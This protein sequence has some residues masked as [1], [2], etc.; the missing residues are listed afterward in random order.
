MDQVQ[1]KNNILIVDDTPENLTVLLQM[2]TEQGYRVRPALSGEIALNAVQADPPDLILLDILMPEMDGYEVCSVLKADRQTEQIPIIFISALSEV[3]DI[4]KAFQS[5]GVDYVTKPFQMDEVL[6]RVRTHLG[7]Q[8]AVREKEE[9]QLLLQTILD[10]IENVIVTVDAQMRIINANRPLDAIC[11]GMPGAEGSFQKSLESGNCPCAEALRQTLESNGPVKEYRVKCSCEGMDRTLVLNTV[12]LIKRQDEVGGAVLVIKDIT[13][14]AAL[15][16]SLL[17]QHS[18]H[19]IIG[20]SEE[21]QK[22][23]TLLERTSELDVNM[24]ICGESGTG[25]ELIAEAIH[26]ASRR[27]AGPLV[28]VNCAALTESLLESELFGHVRGSFTGAV[29]DRV[30]RCQAAE[31]G[32]LFLDEIGDISPQFQAKLL[33]FLEQKEFE[34]IG[35]SKS[36]KAD[37]RVVAATNRDLS[38]KVKVR[39][40]REDLFFRL[41]GVLVQLPSLGE[42]VDDIPL[43]ASHFVHV[44]RKSLNKNIESISE[45]VTKLFLEYPW[46]GNVRELKSAI[47]YACALCP[48]EVI[49]K[50]HLPP[51]LF[52]E[53]AL[54]KLSRR[55]MDASNAEQLSQGSDKE[56]ILAMLE[57][58]DWNKAKAA[59]RL[60]VSRATLYAKLSK[61]GIEAPPEKS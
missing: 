47:H 34:R 49:Q 10:S 57:N 3:E 18:Y 15:E 25:K 46:P 36:R 11:A 27:A 23:F 4:V 26:Y 29:K 50:E 16:K 22:V 61:Y 42:R 55:K 52:A 54:E 9:A 51:E 14:L 56:S 59:R 24:L 48:E 6:A 17:E 44:F 40:F 7:L 60:G 32:T 31:G 30:G 33:R 45:E 13:R 38:A 28:K 53:T 5:G 20:K 43:L 39:E 1:E 12:P 19:S 37:V 41:K 35:E 2:L 21:M 58:T 8:N